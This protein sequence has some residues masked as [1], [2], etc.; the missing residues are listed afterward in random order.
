[1]RFQCPGKE[2]LVGTLQVDARSHAEGISGL[3]A[4]G[5][6]DTALIARLRARIAVGDGERE[7]VSVRIPFTGEPLGTIPRATEADV[8]RAVRRARTA[9]PGWARVSA[10]ERGKLLL[11]FHDLVLARQEQ[12]LDLIQLESGKARRHALEEI[13]DTLTVARHYGVHAPHYLR[14][15]R[16]AG[17]LPLVTAVYEH[18]HPVGVVGVVAPWNF[19]LI[20]GITDVLAALAAGNAVLLRPD[21]QSSFTALW[22]AELLREAGLPDDVLQVVTGEGSVLGPAMIDQVDF[23]MFTGSTRT[24]R[25]VAEQA[26]ERLIGFS[27]ELGG[28]NPMIVLDD[29]DIEAAVDGLV[30]GAFVGAG[31][32]CVS[33]ERVY[34]PRAMFSRFATRLVWRVGGMKLSPALAYDADMGSLTVPRQLATVE[35]HVADAIAHGATLLIG[36]RRRPDIGPLFYEPTVLTDVTASMRMYAEETFGPVVALYAYDTDDEAVQRANDTPYGLNASVWSRNVRRARQ[37]A[38]RIRAGTVNVNEAY[39]ATWLATASPIGGMKQSGTG[40]RHGAEGILKYTET[41]TIAVQRLL[42]LAPIAFVREEIY[43]RWMP[44]LVGLLR[45]IPGVR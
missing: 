3:G 12:A 43:S 14:R 26:A 44:R 31:Q 41:Q 19:P 27:L 25:L 22:A 6:V 30:R 4:T 45:R 38:T 11:R 16:R 33:I 42:P 20:L 10:K 9:H 32:V 21:E 34:I 35:A 1:V 18:R 24:G 39:G 28:K 23:M 36:G 29:A 37:I 8:A 7:L 2:H 5:S 15:R 17:G 40:R 13:L